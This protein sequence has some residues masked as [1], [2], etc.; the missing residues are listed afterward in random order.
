MLLSG[1]EKA[2]GRAGT[3]GPDFPVA[4][5]F[6]PGEL[7]CEPAAVPRD[8][9]DPAVHAIR[10]DPR[11]RLALQVAGAAASLEYLI[12]GLAPYKAVHC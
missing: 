10:A 5:I 12:R 1:H 6:L 7:G 3:F 2:P 11:P 4:R 9:G 8:R